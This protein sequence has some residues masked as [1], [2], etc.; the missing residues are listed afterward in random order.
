MAPN[1]KKRKTHDDGSVWTVRKPATTHANRTVTQV[2]AVSIDGRRATVQSQA[3]FTEVPTQSTSQ[4]TPAVP[5]QTDQTLANDPGWEDN[6]EAH[7]IPPPRVRAKEKRD[8]DFATLV[9]MDL[10]TPRRL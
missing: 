8:S 3:V 5:S 1:K 2:H 7:D 4:I 9:C 6:V 10:Q